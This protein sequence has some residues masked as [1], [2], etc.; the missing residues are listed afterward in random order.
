MNENKILH[1]ALFCIYALAE[2]YNKTSAYI[3]SIF[4]KYGVSSYII[5]CYEALHT[6]GTYY[7]VDDLEGFVFDRG[8]DFNSD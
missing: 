8:G 1:F 4:E 2:K 7:I 3:F 6:Q 5:E